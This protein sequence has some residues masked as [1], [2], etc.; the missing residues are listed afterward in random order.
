MCVF[1]WCVGVGRR[2]RGYIVNFFSDPSEWNDC[3]VK[4]SENLSEDH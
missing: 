4:W 2:W 1:D 3:V